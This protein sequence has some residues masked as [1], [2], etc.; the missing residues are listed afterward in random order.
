M[1]PRKRT[2]LFIL[3]LL[4]ATPVWLTAQTAGGAPTGT[5]PRNLL[6]LVEISEPFTAEDRIVLYESLLM[7]LH[8]DVDDVTVFELMDPRQ[9]SPSDEERSRLALER[10][11][12]AWLYVR[13]ERD[14]EG[15]AIGARSVDL[16]TGEQAFEV[17]VARSA[18]RGMERVFWSDVV[19][20]VDEHYEMIDREEQ[21]TRREEGP[22][23]SADGAV[24]IRAVPGTVLTGLGEE[25]VTVGSSGRVSVPLV[26]FGTYTVRAEADG[27]YPQTE[28]FYLDTRKRTIELTQRP[29]SSWAV[30]LYL[31]GLLYPGVEASYYLRPGFWYLRFGLNTFALGLPLR[32][33]SVGERTSF[34]LTHLNLSTGLYIFGA[35]DSIVRGYASV[36]GL[37]RLNHLQ[38]RPIA[39]D[40][41]SAFGVFLATGVEVSPSPFVRF[42]LEYRPLLYFS[43]RPELLAAGYAKALTEDGTE[44]T[45]ADDLAPP[46]AFFSW[47]ALDY[48]NFNVGVRIQL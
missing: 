39:I 8:T 42:F 41:I 7:R 22:E 24:I 4:L 19:R 33:R 2:P 21:E 26:R 35:V 44:D 12:D 1:K 16:I 29:A 27:Y 10:G 46:Y 38:G 6:V 45:E 9:A 18:V 3:F 13:V 17:S 36:G 37:L 48:T 32:D 14:G 47:G 11:A 34:G 43:G 5:V 40:P 23:R 25:P 20:A 30:E 15:I 31:N 28:D